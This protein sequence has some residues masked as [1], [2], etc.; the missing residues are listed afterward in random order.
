LPFCRQKNRVYVSFKVI[1]RDQ[2]LFQRERERLGV[3]DT[4]QQCASQSGA[5]RYRDCVERSVVAAGLCKCLANDRDHRAQ[6]LARG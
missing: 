1:D 5:L 2:G 6:M 4:D 3:A